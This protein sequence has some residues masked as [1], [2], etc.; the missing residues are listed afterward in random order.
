MLFGDR[1]PARAVQ[2]ELTMTDTTRT[3]SAPL[4]YVTMPT[5]EPDRSLPLQMTT[6]TLAISN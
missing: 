4:Q 5:G 6:D 3:Q 2:N 1:L